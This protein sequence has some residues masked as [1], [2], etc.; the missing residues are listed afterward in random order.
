MYTRHSSGITSV[1]PSFGGW[2]GSWRRI[3]ASSILTHTVKNITS[4]I[5]R[6]SVRSW[7]QSGLAGPSI[8]MRDSAPNYIFL[9]L[10]KNTTS[11]RSPTVFSAGIYAP[12]LSH[13]SLYIIF[14]YVN[15]YFYYSVRSFHIAV[16]K[17]LSRS[18]RL[19]KKIIENFLLFLPWIGI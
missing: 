3:W 12:T 13:I 10:H 11:S 17:P 16:Q 9:F 6:F 4:A 5:S 2:E 8:P 1:L 18:K 7:Y 14:L 19:F 15:L